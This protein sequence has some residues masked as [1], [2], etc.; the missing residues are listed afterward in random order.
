[1]APADLTLVGGTGKPPTESC[2]EIV[3]S[4]LLGR[5]NTN[6]ILYT[7]GC[8]GWRK[9]AMTSYSMKRFSVRSVVHKKIE[10]TKTCKVKGKTKLVGTQVL[11]RSWMWLKKIV[12]HALKNR[13]D[14]VIIPRLWE[15]IYQFAYRH[16]QKN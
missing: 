12:P 3:F 15:Y 4:G 8:Q 16:N 1:M 2:T 11:D 7:D 13:Y 9:A 10:W 14:K 6:S 5:C